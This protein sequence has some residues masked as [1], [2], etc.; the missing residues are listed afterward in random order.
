MKSIWYFP[1]IFIGLVVIY[2]IMLI[3][4]E[5]F[6][7]PVTG[8][9]HFLDGLILIWAALKIKKALINSP[10]EDLSKKYFMWFFACT[11]IFQ[12]MIGLPHLL[13]FSDKGMFPQALAWSYTQGH[14]FLFLALAFTIM[15]PLQLYFPDRKKL[16]K[17]VFTFFL[18]FGAVITVINIFLP[19]NPV[20]DEKSGLT[21]FNA[22]PIVG[23]LIPI[24]VVLSWGPSAIIFIYKGIRSRSNRLVLIRSLLLGI[25]LLILLVFG[26]MHDLA[27]TTL[28]FFVADIFTMLGFLTIAAGIF[29][30]EAS[31]EK[32]TTTEKTATAEF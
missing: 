8:I 26:P 13:L 5:T 3:L 21:F 19:N 32:I 31:V 20:F 4:Q 24:I 7:V 29:Y 9:F 27:K 23:R 6:L 11:G 16:K 18:L 12:V 2:F 25:G 14:M 15:V 30:R 10:T 1:A 17:V 28:Q 22:D